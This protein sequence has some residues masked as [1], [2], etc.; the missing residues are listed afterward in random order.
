MMKTTRRCRWIGGRGEAFFTNACS[1]N[2]GK[3]SHERRIDQHPQRAQRNDQRKIIIKPA[4]REHFS[5]K[6]EIINLYIGRPR[7]EKAEK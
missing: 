6:F 4:M 7:L 5:N 2:G 3:T 1:V